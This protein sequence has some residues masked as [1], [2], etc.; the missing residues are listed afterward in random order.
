MFY[1]FLDRGRPRRGPGGAL[2][3]EPPPEDP[4][5]AFEGPPESLRGFFGAVQICFHNFLEFPLIWISG[6]WGPPKIGGL[7]DTNLY[8]FVTFS[9][10]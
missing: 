2:P 4:R 3:L 9:V 10:T 6:F 5:G 1:F 8:G 7:S